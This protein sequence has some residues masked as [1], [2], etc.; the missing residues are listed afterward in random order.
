MH[1]FCELKSNK[2]A[3]IKIVDILY[4]RIIISN[5]FSVLSDLFN[6]KSQHGQDI[7]VVYVFAD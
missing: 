1:K 2:H 7:N 4:N 6:L 3:T 5:Y